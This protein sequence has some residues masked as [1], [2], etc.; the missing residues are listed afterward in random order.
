MV[1]TLHD[2]WAFCG[3]EH[4]IPEEKYNYKYSREN[5]TYKS[6]YF[7]INHWSWKRK[8]KHW[9]KSIQIITP[10]RWMKEL[11]G[12]SDIMSNWPI[13]VI[14]NTIDTEY[15]KPI[16]KSVARELLGFKPNRPLI[17]FGAV[18]GTSDPRKG[19]DLLREALHKIKGNERN[20]ALL[21]IGEK[22]DGIEKRNGFDTY[23]LGHFYDDLSLKLIYNVADIVLI[24]SRQDNLPN[25]GVEA[26]AC[27]VPVVAFDTC[28]LPDI[29]KHRENGWL[30]TAFD[31]DSFA[32]GIL[33][34]LE[35]EERK[36]V[37]SSNA[38]K[39]AVLNYSSEV[40]S[41]KHMQLY[42]KVIQ[43]DK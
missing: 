38:R 11:T 1:W 40:V 29:V 16:Q 27:G 18:G 41:N 19:F 6:S 25:F 34:I 30:A 22:G 17:L 33:W 21:I 2:M 36:K 26:L 28:G 37:L 15:W 43:S 39:Y 23:S 35:D 3:A 13:E 31:A 12:S 9:N 20:P 14:S 24:P 32:E 7:D 5:R 4:Y 42:Q 10:S 8:K